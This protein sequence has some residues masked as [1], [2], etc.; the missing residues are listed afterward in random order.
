M[1]GSIFRVTISGDVSAVKGVSADKALRH[2]GQEW[3]TR[4]A[5][6]QR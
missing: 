6:E 5:L 3:I 4:F 1:R 2:C